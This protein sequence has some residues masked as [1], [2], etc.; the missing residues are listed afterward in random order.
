MI[1]FAPLG[2]LSLAEGNRAAFFDW[3]LGGLRVGPPRDFDLG[4]GVILDW[5]LTRD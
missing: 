1:P 5:I 3:R 4:I 2:W